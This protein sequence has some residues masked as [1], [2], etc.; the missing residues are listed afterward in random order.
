MHAAIGI[1][2]VRQLL[3]QLLMQNK[4]FP[5]YGPGIDSRLIRSASDFAFRVRHAFFKELRPQ[6]FVN[7]A[8]ETPVLS[9]LQ[10]EDEAG[11]LHY[12]DENGEEM[13]LPLWTS[14]FK[15]LALQLSHVV[16][17]DFRATARTAWAEW[18]SKHGE[19]FQSDQARRIKAYRDRATG[20]EKQRRYF[21]TNITAAMTPL[22]ALAEDD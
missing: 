14:E 11:R 8:G 16:G 9:Q 18:V 15:S 19:Q 4:Y 3:A 6:V 1:T 10:Y 21:E 7:F 22:A 20:I 17:D 13:P 12:I 5:N 2:Y